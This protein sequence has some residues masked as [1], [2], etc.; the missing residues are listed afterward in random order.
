M[1]PASPGAGGLSEE[2]HHVAVLV[3]IDLHARRLGGQAGD[4]PHVAAE[5]IE[6]T[7]AEGR[8][9]I[10]DGQD[11]SRRTALQRRVVRQ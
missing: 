5:R 4:S 1:R 9:D 6:K 2:P 7:G 3:Q 11:V 8:P 10:P